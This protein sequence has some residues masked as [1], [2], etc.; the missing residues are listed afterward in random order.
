[1]MTRRRALGLSIFAVV[2]LAMAGLAANQPDAPS[3]SVRSAQ[4]RGETP[5]A[6]PPAASPSAVALPAAPRQSVRVPAGPRIRGDLSDPQKKDIAMR[7]VSSAENSTLEWTTQYAYIE[8]IGDGRGYTGGIVG[9]CSGTG[10]MKAVVERYSAAVPRSRLAAYLPA[11]RRVNGSDSHAGLDP[12]FAGEWRAAAADPAFRAAQDAE[13]DRMYFGPAL[14]QAKQDG[15]RMLGQFVYFDAIVMHGANA[16][17]KLRR[18]AA[19]TA[20]PP[21]RGG[22]EAA[23]LEAFLTARLALM[24]AE[25]AHEDVS[26][27]EDAQRVF[28]RE[29]NFDLDPPLR[30][31]VYGDAYEIGA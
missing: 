31:K 14:S 15:L 6:S 4:A 3:P 1:M 9:F 8:D 17:V 7:L 26:R 21:A 10:D 22:D 20:P 12:G 23:Y 30:W 25:E 28:L 13:R 19:E 11:L 24:E 2:S 5:A 29:R 18:T 16:L 27:I